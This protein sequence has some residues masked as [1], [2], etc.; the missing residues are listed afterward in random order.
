MPNQ[1]F[2]TTI[3]SRF[4]VTDPASLA[5]CVVDTATTGQASFVAAALGAQGAVA[6]LRPGGSGTTVPVAAGQSASEFFYATAG[7]KISVE[8]V[9]TGLPD[10]CGFLQLHDP[11]GAGIATACLIGGHGVTDPVTL[12]TTGTYSVVVNPPGHAAG[13][14]HLTVVQV[15]DS[16]TTLNVD[17]PAVPVTV[18]TPGGKAGL[19]FAATTGQTI[20]V[21]VTG[22]SLDGCGQFQLLDPAGNTLGTACV[23]G[24]SGAIDR[25]TL[26]TSGQYQVV[27]DPGPGQTGQATVQVNTVADQQVN[28]T[29]GGAA[30]T[31]T[32]TRPG[33]LA[34]FTFTATAGQA[35]TVDVT[36][37]TLTLGCGQVSLLDPSGASVGSGCVVGGTGTFT[38]PPLT[39]T[40]QYIVEVTPGGETGTVTLRVSAS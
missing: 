30:A 32:L 20:Y 34:R 29:L 11:N 12:P 3:C 9:T 39:T 40:G 36:A 31:A 6:R 37:A 23:S 22:S 15:A 16:S 10:G 28:L 26:S 24:G 14:V 5:A 1:A 35:V 33:S 7:Q 13:T 27:L 25:T 18:T 21:R 38:S 4:G 17:G 2:A 19:A 8:A